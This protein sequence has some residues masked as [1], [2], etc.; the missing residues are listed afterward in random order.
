M[1]AH[2]RSNILL[3]LLTVLICCVCYPAVLWAIG[4]TVFR[5][6]A[7]G[8]LIYGKDGQPIGSR[9]IAQPFK[10]NGYFHPR[11][12]AVSY[13]AAASGGS[14][15]GASN[16]NLRKRVVASIGPILKYRDGRPVG[17][18]IVAWVRDG[19]KQDPTILSKWVQADPYLTERWGAANSNFLKEWGSKHE[20]N[21][22]LWRRDH[23]DH[24]IGPTELAAL[25]FA[26]YGK[27]ETTAWP[28]SDGID[29]Q[30]AFFEL[31]W[32]DHA[33]SDVEP[34]PADLVT[35]SGSGLDPHITLKAALYQLDRV[36]ANRAATKKTDVATIKTEIERL[37]RNNAHAPL[38]GVAGVE[39]IN[40]LEVNLML[41]E[42][43]KS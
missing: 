36:A 22:A 35:T 42:Q 33:Q 21:V 8:S 27:G 24:E 6:Q 7:E 12:S 43:F 23:S 31:W 2:L 5:D 25:Y 39:L 32:T 38:G 16:P 30:V 4:Q 26:S 34:I 13:N 29:L 28:E 1:F 40:V 19:L 20:A 11:P 37:L 18:D 14:N 17:P 3:L 10:G 15:W 9:L 41:D